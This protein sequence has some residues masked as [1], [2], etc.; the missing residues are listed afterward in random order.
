MECNLQLLTIA[1]V[2]TCSIFIYSL[3]LSIER[4]LDS[5]IRFLIYF[6]EK[7]D[8]YEDKNK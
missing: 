1:I 7:I 5:I 2:L 4:K 3:F 6:D 8:E